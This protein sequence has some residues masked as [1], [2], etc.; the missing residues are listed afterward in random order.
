V[1][2]LAAVPIVLFALH[3]QDEPAR[4]SD[5]WTLFQGLER[6][7]RIEFHAPE[8]APERAATKL[9]EAL[10]LQG[11]YEVTLNPEKADSGA[12]RV[13][14]GTP[15]DIALADLATYVGVEAL[16]DGFHFQER[17][18]REPG[19]ALVAVFEDPER[20]GRPLCIFLGNDLE[21]LSVYLYELPS[22][23]R[24]FLR[25]WA[26]GDVAVE[27]AL[28]PS[29]RPRPER[30]IDYLARREQVFGETKPEEFPGVT[31]YAADPPDPERWPV[32]AAQLAEVRDHVIQWLG[33]KDPEAPIPTVE[34]YLYTHAEELEACVGARGLGQA[35]LLRPRAHVLLAPG[36]PDDGGATFARVLARAV[37]GPPDDLWLL[38]GVSVGAA[39]RWWGKPLD[40]W[41]GSLLVAGLFP[42]LPEITNPY[43]NSVW[44][45]H[46]L[47]PARAYLFRLVGGTKGDPEK[48]RAIWNG[49]AL[50]AQRLGP[51]LRTELIKLQNVYLRRQRATEAEAPAPAPLDM[52]RGIALVES[53]NARY[54]SRA[55]GSALE[56]ARA[57]VPG[58]RSVSL[59]VFAA[60]EQ[61]PASTCQL[62]PR[63]LRASASDL[64]LAQAV[65]EAH[66]REM[67]VL[68]A[69]EPL[70]ALGG[71]W[72]DN[73]AYNGFEAQPDFW[74]RYRPIVQ[75]YA[76]LGELLSVELLSLGA[77][78]RDASRTDPNPPLRDDRLL[79]VRRAGWK[80][81]LDA[82]RATYH[83]GL[84]YTARFPAEAR[85]IGFWGELDCIG[86]AFFPRFT[87][88]PDG[89]ELRRLLRT[90]LEDALDL[91]VRWNKPLCLVQLGFP[92]RA[93][94]W[95]WSAVPRG[96]SDP[97][98]Q[99]RYF[100]ALADVLGGKLENGD[101][102][103]GVYLW[104]WPVAED[105]A[106]AF[107]LRGRPAQGVLS[108]LFQR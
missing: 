23:T 100:T 99:G 39:G 98:A 5:S 43:A 86:L 102:L 19:D 1:T 61:D 28:E 49:A 40:A 91:A 34:L 97:E 70:T 101:A 81:L 75:H 2:L 106:S 77:N 9:A 4:G 25:V 82:A 79:E 46:V 93:D 51:L 48:L 67:S 8:G 32:Y 20:P 58:P 53:P 57:R 66:G 30:K 16:T 55:V 24:P 37:A 104:S 94:S 56:A 35:N 105:D 22:L 45:E 26:D 7:G 76:L 78:L 69:L 64:A 74:K 31:L 17:E 83:G 108:R 88:T 41:I 47:A 68:L 38:D 18:Y 10:A 89:R 33:S 103:A 72:A 36:V 14:L 90:D 73:V 52:G 62:E 85:D 95:K 84:T 87:G 65:A 42:D 27:C 92:A 107:S 60:V 3:A 63:G 15:D 50:P 6:S 44:S 71:S 29:G 54:A 12:V 59:T 11:R 21:T 96:A 13:L 80:S